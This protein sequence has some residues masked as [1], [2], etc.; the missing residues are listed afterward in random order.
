MPVHIG[1][2][3]SL[4]LDQAGTET[5]CPVGHGVL[6]S[7]DF[8][9]TPERDQWTM[10]DD[11]WAQLFVPSKNMMDMPGNHADNQP[12]EAGPL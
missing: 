3:G 11:S 9:P 8:Q 7:A 4:L 2:S 12:P 10:F 6:Y 5:A 1:Q